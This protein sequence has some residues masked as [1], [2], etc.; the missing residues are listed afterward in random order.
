V[1]WSMDTVKRSLLLSKLNSEEER[2]TLDRYHHFHGHSGMWHVR[3]ISFFGLVR[4]ALL[5][6]STC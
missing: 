1:G 3:L 5:F 2:A 4:A 6:F